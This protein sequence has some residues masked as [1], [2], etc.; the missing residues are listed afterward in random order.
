MTPCREYQ[1]TIS[2]AGY[3]VRHGEAAKRFQTAYVH[4]QIMIMAG[5]NIEGKEVMHICDNPRCF[6][7]DHLRVG[8]HAENMA[9]MKAKGR[10]KDRSQG[11]LTPIPHGTNA[12]YARHQH[13]GEIPC[14]QCKKARQEY[15]RERRVAKA[16]YDAAGMSPWSATS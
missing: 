2:S 14:D 5:H 7:Y 3:G 9:D 1:G 10:Y 15:D 16:L 13:R 12:G 4:R 11:K 6:R 8:T